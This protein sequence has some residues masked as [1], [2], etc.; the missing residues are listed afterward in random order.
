MTNNQIVTIEVPHIANIQKQLGAIPQKAPVV[1]SRA[2]NK[3]ITHVRKLMSQEVRQEY[4]VKD[5]VVKKTMKIKKASAARLSGEVI[6]NSRDKVKLIEFK[7]SP[8]KAQPDR[9]DHY[10]AKVKK[11]GSL[12]PLSGSSDRSA[13]F[14]AKMKSGHVGVFQRQ[15]G[16]ARLPVA[17]LY[18]M[19]I[20]QMFG[21]RKISMETV[22]QGQDFMKKALDQEIRR[23]LEVSR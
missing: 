17:E 10:K 3:T 8:A 20:P 4:I 13:A 5:R 9:M 21:S 7:V 18:G 19:A 14:V 23:M 16:A 6:S 12:K 22:K 1:M 2:I 11:S 15:G